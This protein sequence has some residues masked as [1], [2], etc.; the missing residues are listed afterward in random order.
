L[1]T[2]AYGLKSVMKPNI[3]TSFSTPYGKDAMDAIDYVERPDSDAAD[4]SSSEHGSVVTSLFRATPGGRAVSVPV[5]RPSPR[6]SASSFAGM[7]GDAPCMRAIFDQIQRVAPTDATVTICGESGTGKELAARAIHDLSTRAD[8]AFIAV[9]CGAIPSNLVEAEFFGYER[10]AFTGAHRRHVG[11]FE[12]A[13]GGTLFLD[14]IAEMPLD[15]QVK[16][17]RALETGRIARVG[18]SAEV[19]V[20]VRVVA[21]TNRDPLQAVVDGKLREDLY[22]RLAV[23]V[24]R[25]PALRERGDDATLIAQHYLEDLNRRYRTSKVFGADARALLREAHWPGNVRELR[26]C[27]ERGFI[28]AE[29]EITLDTPRMATPAG[30]RIGPDGCIRFPLGSSIADVEREMILATIQHFG[31]SKRRAADALGLSRKTVYN[32]LAEYAAENGKLR[33]ASVS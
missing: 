33:L 22:Y 10:G 27:V 25:L 18:G 13:G 12:R 6:D 8:A 28:M 11:Y 21:A 24:M 9:N 7:V 30:G 20:D 16:L 1:R 5:T 4:G 14:E 23:F 15:L 17:L 19:P 31:G 32:K 29:R 2:D 3:A 26:N